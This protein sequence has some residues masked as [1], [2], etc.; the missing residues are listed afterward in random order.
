MVVLWLAGVLA[1][2]GYNMKAEPAANDRERIKTWIGRVKEA[3][4]TDRDRLPLLIREVES[5]AKTTTDAPSAALLHSM[6]AEMY[7]QYYLRN[8]WSVDSRTPVEGFLPEDIREWTA[9][10][11]VRKIK[12]ELEASLQPAGIL[13]QTPAARFAEAL[14]MGKDSPALRPTLYDFLAHRALEIQPSDSVF[15]ELLAFRRSQPDGKAALM[16]ELDYLQYAAADLYQEQGQTAYEAS[17]DS[18]LA[19]H[20]DRDFSV[21]VAYA[22]L[23]LLQR[24]RA[25]AGSPD[26]IRAL[27]YG[28]CK[29]FLAH[30]PQYERIGLVR[31]WLAALEEKGIRTTHPRT[32]Y[33]G[34]SL[35]VELRYTYINSVTVRIYRSRRKIEETFQ[36]A[37]QREGKAETDEWV[38]EIAVPLRLR[39]SYT[40]H[41]TVL[42]IPME[43]PGL[44]E[45]VVT[46]AGTS[47]RVAGE[48]SVSRMAAVPRPAPSKQIEVLVTDYL[49]GRPLDEVTVNYYGVNRRALQWIGSVQ[50][51]RDGI[52]LIP[53]GGNDPVYACQPWLPDDAMSPLAGVYTTMDRT[54][55]EA[56]TEVSLFT[57]RGI[58]RPGQTVFFKGIAYVDDPERPRVAA[59][60]R[61]D[62]VLRDANHKEIATQ[63][64]TSNSYGSFSGSFALPRQTLTGRFTLSS[65]NH[66]AFIRVEE[67]K[68]PS[69]GIEILP[70]DEEIAF[71]DEATVRGRAQTFSGVPLT[72]GTVV[73][74]VLRRPHF[75]RSYDGVWREEQIAEGR[76]SIE[77]DGSFTFRFRPEKDH[78]RPSLSYQSYEIIAQA[79]DSKGETQ[80]ARSSFSAGDRSLILS[81]NLYDK[82][83]KDTATVR[84]TARTLNGEPAT[85]TGAYAFFLLEETSPREGVYNEGRRLSEGTFTTGLPLGDNVL[86][87]LPSGRIRLRLS[88]ADSK[89][90]PIN[91]QQDFILYSRNDK[92]PPVFSHIWL[93]EDKKEYAPGEEAVLL[94]GSSDKD[95]YLLYELFAAGKNVAR[96][97]VELSQE[98]R[99]FRIPFLES[100]GEGLV[101]SFT[102]IKAGKLHT[103]QT[104]L[105]RK[106]PDRTLTITPESFRDKLLPG[107][108]ERWRF[109]LSDAASLP[110]P[111]EALMGMYDASLDHIF[112]F[113]WRFAPLTYTRP[114]YN[115]FTESE[116]L[117]LGYASDVA[118]G[119]NRGQTPT[120][121][122]DRLDWQGAFDLPAYPYST[123]NSRVMQAASSVMKVQ[124]VETE[125]ESL[126]FNDSA[127]PEADERSAAG[128]GMPPAAT[129]SAA[130][131]PL[132][133]VL[134]ETAFF[135]PSLFTDKDGNIVV[136]FTLPESHTTWKLQT[137]A[138]TA[139]L[140][141]G[142]STHEVITQKPFM[143]LPHLPRFI[144]RGDEVHLSAQIIN[145]SEKDVSGDARLELFNPANDELLL[146]AD[147]QPFTL[148]AGS[149]TTVR[150]TVTLPEAPDLAGCR[151]IAASASG[152]DGEQHW[153]PVLPDEIL[154]TE[155]TPF[156]LTGEGEKQVTTAYVESSPTRRP[157]RMTLEYSNQPMWYAIQALPALTEPADDDVLSWFASYYGHSLATSIARSN[158]RIREVI[159]RWNMQ[160][161]TSA[162]HPSPLEGNEELKAF[163]LEETPWTLDAKTESEQ[164]QRLSL[165]F[166][167]NRAS[168]QREAALREL[169]RQQREDGAWGW[170]KGLY[171]S[172]DITLY[173]LEGMTHLIRLN[174]ATTTSGGQEK[175]MQ[176]KALAYVDQAF[177]EDYERLRQSKISL[178]NYLP[179][180]QQIH[181][182][183]VRSLYREIP[184][185]A[186]AQEVIRYFTEQAGKQWQKTSL[187]EKGMIALLMHRNGKEKATKE[188]VAWLRKTATKSPEQ[189]MYWANNRREQ[190]FLVSPTDVHSL[191]MS[192]FR[193][194][195]ADAGETDRMRQWLLNRK[196]VTNWGSTPSTVNAIHS[197][198]SDGNEWLA[199]TNG[200]TIRWG[201]MTLHTSAGE[202]A[203]GYLKE[204]VAGKDITPALHTVTLHK[205]G[206]SPAWGAVYYQ[207]FESIG[208]VNTQSAAL[209]VE[210]K[211]FVETNNG[212]Q[213]QI[214]P[215]S[216]GHPLHTGDKVIVRLTIRADRDMEYV[217]LK[218]LRAGCFEPAVQRSGIRSFD[219]QLCYHSS[220]D[221]SEN[222]FFDRLPAGAHVL[223]YAAY[224][225]RS[226]HYAGGIATLQCLYA[227]E[228]VTHTASDTIFVHE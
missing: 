94:F 27:E 186:D 166:D 74:R 42:S 28:L 12:E 154:V 78:Q 139:D 200:T 215:V 142:L 218:D 206:P 127:L 66:F 129:S 196:R 92:R 41:D 204:T 102:F 188:I 100:Y 110:A 228:F 187:Y 6:T 141:Y 185:P 213:R 29:D 208:N 183:Y 175:E 137:L 203:T 133:T 89:G 38:K 164:K 147:I 84:M 123:R 148:P 170:F 88:A 125:A 191:L 48:F 134:N 59:G 61:F 87:S 173:L 209:S 93:P 55:A 145:L 199:E 5:E 117:R 60:Q 81:S 2:V 152:S 26:S 171:P 161:E 85:T 105:L 153:L 98:N 216:A 130:P 31:D 116:G 210:K 224:V 33:P 158:P 169:L 22:K 128:A 11:F 107:S 226:G 30:F 162:P 140:K 14:E 95:V 176:R 181:Y 53:A 131:R 149:T 3:L 10:L 82:V 36:A 40:V 20:A 157:H 45:Y 104:A 32:V 49:S 109:R 63:S 212:A 205:E 56:A 13:R 124:D 90:R 70:G 101:A 138:H 178:R 119:K 52:A 225:S 207:Y 197:L 114:Y 194:L 15:K 172:R 155:S 43:S 132:R 79:T 115:R 67:Y 201:D 23:E 163:L 72:G 44:Y 103:Q 126:V 64:F 150:W 192:V 25:F 71:G 75:L 111:A 198:L 165:L 37:P 83:D 189:G 222:F 21:E 73:Y 144:R 151:I 211:L 156:Y 108:H 168:Y 50:T 182:I 195:G 121:S 39:N 7:H 227:P 219:R 24:K 47:L 190:N 17:L 174:A 217:S 57:D 159:A 4:D 202:T 143:T 136:D 122:Y 113:A 51:D 167:L 68:R 77:S 118:T 180:P 112:P 86:S 16:V 34:Q 46:S 62:V 97:R 9:N 65:A 179:T 69:F 120:L 160:Q 19:V 58:Y 96:R 193:T 8:K 18:L 80:E 146:P 223:E 35:E 76:T 214:T 184:A 221:A 220:K 1:S 135:F 54:V 177:R 91:E 99:T 106:R